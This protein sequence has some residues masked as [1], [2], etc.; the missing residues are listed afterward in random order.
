MG[1]KAPEGEESGKIDQ[2]GGESPRDKFIG[3]SEVKKD[4]VF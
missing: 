2:G 4:G 3:I 1:G